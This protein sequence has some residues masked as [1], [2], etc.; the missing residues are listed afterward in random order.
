MTENWLPSTALGTTTTRSGS[1]PLLS[2]SLFKLSQ[3]VTTASALR[4]HSVSDSLR[5][6]SARSL[7]GQTARYL[8]VLPQ[9]SNLVDPGIPSAC[10]TAAA[11]NPFLKFDAACTVRASRTEPPSEL[12]SRR[13]ED[14]HRADVD[15]TGADR[16]SE[17]GGTRLHRQCRKSR[18][19]RSRG[20]TDIPGRVTPATRKSPARW[21]RRCNEFSTLY[22]LMR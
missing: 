5:S 2:I 20:P 11:A 21:C 14:T 18:D 6:G 7:G 4:R 15:R 22:P 19:A 17:S 9:P 10:A 3:M 13:L 8:G 16:Q 12:R 1:M